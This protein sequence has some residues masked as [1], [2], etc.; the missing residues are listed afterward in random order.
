MKRFCCFFLMILILAGLCGCSARAERTQAL[1]GTWRRSDCYDSEAIMEFF[2]YMDLYEEE[3]ALMDPGAIGYVETVTFRE[4]GTYTIAC[5]IE[6]STALAE[7]YYR[8][9]LDAFYENRET[10]EQCYGVSFG[11]M[12]RDSFFRFYVDMYGLEDYEDLVAMLTESTVDPEYLEAAGESGTYRVTARKIYWK[13][14]G[15]RMEQY[16]EYALEGDSL[17]LEFYDGARTYTR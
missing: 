10:L 13:A 16:L 1:E 11:T 14:E 2:V 9:A 3:I 6:E 12:S 17:T 15:Q 8:Q 5:D 7:E 4:D